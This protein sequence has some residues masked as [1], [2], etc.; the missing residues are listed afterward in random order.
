[1]LKMFLDDEE[2]T[3]VSTSGA[4]EGIYLIELDVSDN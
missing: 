2:V 3:L 4:L 1:M